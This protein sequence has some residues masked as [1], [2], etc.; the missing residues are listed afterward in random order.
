MNNLPDQQL[1]KQSNPEP[2]IRNRTPTKGRIRRNRPWAHII[3]GEGSRAD[4]SDRTK[5]LRTN[6]TEKHVHASQGLQE[7]DTEA[8]TLDRVQH[9][10]PEPDTSGDERAAGISSCHPREVVANARHT[11]P[12]LCP[13]G[14]SEATGEHGEEPAV[15]FE[16]ATDDE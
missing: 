4:R 10:E 6:K 15:W 7:D 1:T 2:G 14:S 9:A 3:R 12:D 13:A 8:E 11:P 5:D 16:V